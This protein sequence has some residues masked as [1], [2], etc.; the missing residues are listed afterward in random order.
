MSELLLNR[1]D[2]KSEKFVQNL[3]SANKSIQRYIVDSLGL[4][5]DVDIKFHTG[6]RYL[7]N[8]IPDF[9]ITKGDLILALVECKKAD[10]NV[11]EYVRGIGQLMQYEHFSEVKHVVNSRESYSPDFMTVY[12]YPSNIIKN[13]SLNTSNFKYPKST[14]LLEVNI[15]NFI[16][17]SVTEDDRLRTKEAWNGLAAVSQYYFRDNRIYEDYILLRYLTH[18]A[19]KRKNIS[20]LNRKEVINRKDLENNKLRKIQTPN[21]NNWRN[22]F[23]TLSNCGFIDE[24]N[25]PTAAGLDIVEKDFPEFSLEMFKGYIKP[26]AEVIFD[27]LIKEISISNIDL[28]KKIEKKFN[29]IP[30]LFLT[31]SE[32]RYLSSWLN[33]F[34]D[35][36]G[37]LEFQPRNSKRKLNYN[38]FTLGSDDEFLRSI[39]KHTKSKSYIERFE[40]LIKS[41]EI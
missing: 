29:D 36:Y 38:P 34:R 41:G 28:K 17:R 15:E 16:V 4:E 24:H 33:I 25:F 39:I 23:I 26:Y 31:E 1:H 21:N 14:K 9:K 3:V 22:A 10:V 8:I 37:F 18:C 20:I 35:D 27:F 32:T 30:V 40:N 19:K 11:T 13:N 5:Y 6:D 2:P 7:N 12:L